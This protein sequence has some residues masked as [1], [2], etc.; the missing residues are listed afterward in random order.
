MVRLSLLLGVLFF[1]GCTHEGPIMQEEAEVI[2]LVYIPATHGLGVGPI[3]GG[4]GGVSVT[5]VSTDEV[6]AVVF[7]CFTHRHTFSLKSKEVYNNV[8]VGQRVILDYVEVLNRNN[9]V[10][11]YRTVR[12]H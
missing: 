1:N 12:V 11:D 6:W 8:R 5:S 3:I 2:Q 9:E 7:R 4:E 10:V